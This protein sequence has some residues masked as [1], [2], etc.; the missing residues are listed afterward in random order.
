M[1]YYIAQPRKPSFPIW[2]GKIESN[3]IVSCDWL[4]EMN[5]GGSF[6]KCWFLSFF[7]DFF[8]PDLSVTFMIQ[9]YVFFL[10]EN[11]F[12]FLAEFS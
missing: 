4:R 1:F 11:H 5:P 9:E 12:F 2:L 10:W 6:D 8:R 3:F 7:L